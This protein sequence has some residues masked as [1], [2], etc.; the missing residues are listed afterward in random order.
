M[1]EINWAYVVVP[2]CFCVLDCVTGFV[3]AAI[4]KQISSTRLREGLMHKLSF[5]LAI[6]LGIVLQVS[7]R[8]F[9]LGFEIPSMGLIASF[10]VLTECVSIVENISEMNPEI[11]ESGI[12]AY[13][14]SDNAN[15][16]ESQD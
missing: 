12:F 14:D 9:D 15:K 6:L 1:F 10:I 2:L 3:K 4:L 11:A 16:N 13:F 5:V 7:S 8:F